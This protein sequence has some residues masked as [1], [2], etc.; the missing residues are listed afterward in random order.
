M[1]A[2]ECLSIPCRFL[3]SAGISVSISFCLVSSFE[4]SGIPPL[5]M[6][7]TIP[8]A[9]LILKVS[10][11]T[12]NHFGPLREKGSIFS[13]DTMYLSKSKSNGHRRA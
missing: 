7:L 2:S 9:T 3:N 4:L 5:A 11:G 10:A 12:P 1:L 13:R 6:T 8:E